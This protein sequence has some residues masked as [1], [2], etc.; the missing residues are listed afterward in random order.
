[1]RGVVWAGLVVVG[2]GFGPAAKANCAF[3]RKPHRIGEKKTFHILSTAGAGAACRTVTLTCK[4]TRSGR[5]KGRAW[6][7]GKHELESLSGYFSECPVQAP[8]QAPVPRPTFA[9]VVPAGKG[10]SADAGTDTNAIDP[11][12]PFLLVGP[13]TRASGASNG[14]ENLGYETFAPGVGFHYLN[15]V[16]PENAWS[17][18]FSNHGLRLVSVVG[19][20]RQIGYSVYPVSGF[21]DPAE[22]AGAPEPAQIDREGRVLLLCGTMPG[23]EFELRVR[24]LKTGFEQTHRFFSAGD[25]PACAP[26]PE[27]TH[28]PELCLD[29]SATNYWTEGECTYPEPTPKPT[30]TSDPGPEP[31]PTEED[32]CGEMAFEEMSGEERESWRASELEAAKSQAV[33][34]NFGN[35]V[36]LNERIYE[37]KNSGPLPLRPHRYGHCLTY[38]IA[39]EESG[40]SGRAIRIHRTRYTT[41]DNSPK[42]TDN[43]GSG[44]IWRR[45]DYSYATNYGSGSIDDPLSVAVSP[46]L[47]VKYGDL[48]FDPDFGWL[49][50]ESQTSAGLDPNNRVD[51]W[52]GKPDPAPPHW[53]T[54][55]EASAAWES[56]EKDG[57]RH[58]FTSDVTLLHFPGGIVSKGFLDANPGRRVPLPGSSGNLIG[59]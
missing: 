2:L 6:H 32:P 23:K 1:M 53:K 7:R 52:L 12:G 13:S 37:P 39:K 18:D 27:P 57:S 44:G 22:T 4:A 14:H 10:E 3:D 28:T 55:W 9:L 5:K 45:R 47:G 43:N 15:T 33:G 38:R 34:K 40:G 20:S 51:Y 24:D 8:A 59:K 21:E 48:L 35:L 17:P 11:I 58:Q 25:G 50:V 19:G 46:E 26:D 31:T 16:R 30:E 49:R 29:P 54:Q 41:Y 56:Y 36:F 42:G